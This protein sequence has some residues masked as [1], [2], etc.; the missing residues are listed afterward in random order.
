MKS[1]HFTFQAGAWPLGQTNLTSF[2]VPPELIKS[3]Q[4]VFI[5]TMNFIYFFIIILNLNINQFNLF[6]V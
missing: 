1:D 2:A 3:V 4:M 6:L 5:L